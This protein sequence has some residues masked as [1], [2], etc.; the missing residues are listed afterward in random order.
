VFTCDPAVLDSPAAP[1]G[2]GYRTGMSD[3]RI[4]KLESSLTSLR[5]QVSQMDRDRRA[6]R[7]R[8]GFDLAACTV[9]GALFVLTATAWRTATDDDGFVNEVTTL[10][11]MVPE[12]WQA[13]VTLLLVLMLAAGT[14]G[15]FIGEAGR[16]THLFFVAVAI[17]T[18][19]AI[20]FIVGQVEP[21]GWY[22]PEDT[23]AGAGRWLA[24]LTCLALA[25]THGAR[26]NEVRH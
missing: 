1:T 24:G 3:E 14:L 9:A 8:T 6:D 2:R 17:L 26:A 11:G 19:L 13:V 15:A 5:R 10:W 7:L 22:D 21:S 20:A 4:E 23:D 25:I 18:A 16:H 12:G